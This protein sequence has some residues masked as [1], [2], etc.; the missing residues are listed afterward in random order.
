MRSPGRKR[1]N[2]HALDANVDSSALEMWADF[3]RY[4]GSPEHKSHPSFAGP[5]RL[6]SDATQCPKHLTDPNQITDWLKQGL[7]DGNVSAYRDAGGY[8]RYVWGKHLD[9]WFE[10]RLVNSEQGTYK[11]YPILDEEVPSAILR[12]QS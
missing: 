12:R 5:P 8:P 4:V 1:P 6:R 9:R 11:G 10:A 2:P 3:V 7:R